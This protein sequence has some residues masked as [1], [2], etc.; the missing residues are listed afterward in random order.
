MIDLKEITRRQQIGLQ[1]VDGLEDVEREL[2][3]YYC[4][5]TGEQLVNLGTQN[6]APFDEVVVNALRVGL[7]L[8]LQLKVSQGKILGRS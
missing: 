2:I 8:G 7:A 1:Q 3:K 6:K 4:Q 5:L